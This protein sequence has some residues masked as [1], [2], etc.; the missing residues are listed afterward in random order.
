[1][2]PKHNSQKDIKPEKVYNA[3]S[4]F[5]LWV[6]FAMFFFCAETTTTIKA[7]RLSLMYSIATLSRITM[8]YPQG[9]Q[10]GEDDDDDPSPKA[11]F[12]WASRKPKSCYRS[13]YCRCAFGL[14]CIIDFTGW[15]KKH[16]ISYGWPYRAYWTVNI[17]LP[18]FFPRLLIQCQ[19]Y[20]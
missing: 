18:Q 4:L 3:I 1:M 9:E 12:D 2:A 17:I 6:L 7:I 13:L 8:L 20:S 19:N 5:C 15:Y 16:P 14:A 11:H 10:K